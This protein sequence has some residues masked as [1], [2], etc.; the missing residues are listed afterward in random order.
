MWSKFMNDRQKKR[1]R[2]DR[3]V[4]TGEL[5]A[6]PSEVAGVANETARL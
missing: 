6:L 3:I 5:Y 2:H 4:V 1:Q